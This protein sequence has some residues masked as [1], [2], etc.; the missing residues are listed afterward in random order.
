MRH[1][2]YMGPDGSEVAS[3]SLSRGSRVSGKLANRARVASFRSVSVA[4]AV[5]LAANTGSVPVAALRYL[6]G[7]Y[8]IREAGLPDP[9]E[10]T[11][12]PVA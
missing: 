2:R 6:F 5:K 12:G 1:V 7:T 9:E 11:A 8:Y 10:W 3:V 4:D